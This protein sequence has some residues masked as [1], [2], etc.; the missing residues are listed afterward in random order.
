MLWKQLKCFCVRSAQMNGGD[1]VVNFYEPNHKCAAQFEWCCTHW[2]WAGSMERVRCMEITASPL[3]VRLT[4]QRTL[5]A[6]ECSWREVLAGSIGKQNVRTLW[7][8]R[9]HLVPHNRYFPKSWH[10]KDG[11]CRARPSDKARHKERH[12]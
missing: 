11:R 1:N 5:C 12:R 6:R 4:L 3:S 9:S 2:A 7:L 8:R 10:S